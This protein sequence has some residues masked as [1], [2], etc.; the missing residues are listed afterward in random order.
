VED[1]AVSNTLRMER[2]PSA[3]SVPGGGGA[4]LYRAGRFYGEGDKSLRFLLLI[5]GPTLALDDQSA[6]RTP[7][8]VLSVSQIWR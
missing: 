3:P 6:H 2:S 5:G 8:P 4:V 7:Y 1:Q